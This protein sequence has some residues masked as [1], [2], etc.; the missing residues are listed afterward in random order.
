[1]GDDMIYA[2]FLHRPVADKEEPF[3][4]GTC[5]Q[6]IDLAEEW[7]GRALRKHQDDGY[8][9]WSVELIDE[10]DVYDMFDD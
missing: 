3:M 6:G 2:I 8:V 4:Y 10:L 7:A 5:N 9:A 1:M